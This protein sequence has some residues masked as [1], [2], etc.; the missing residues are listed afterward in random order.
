MRR[1][2][3]LKI[4]FWLQIV[5]ILL[6]GVIIS[7]IVFFAINYAKQEKYTV[8]F[9]YQ[10]GAI[11]DIKKA[12]VGKGV[13]PPKFDCEG[14]FRGWSVPINN[15]TDDIEAHPQIYDIVEENL[16]YFNSVYVKEGRKV[17][18]DINVGGD[19]S[20]KSG[21]L[22]ISYDDKVLNYIKSDNEDFVT[23]TEEEAGKL[24]LTFDSEESIEESML[25][26]SI[27]FKTKKV[28]AYST[29]LQLSADNVIS[30][31]KNKEVP[32]TFATINN[33]IY[34]LQEVS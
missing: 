10:N 11:I 29:E 22:T 1:T 19:V 18:V 23:V 3:K 9:A 34:F 6:V 15:I 30:E 28:D 20:F 2:C 26:S 33:N 24:K 16:F 25:L 32:A 21:E 5:A 17:T 4:P 14:V 13:K 12:P 8:T 7:G 27:T 31:V